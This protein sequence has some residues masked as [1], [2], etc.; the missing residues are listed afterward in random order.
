MLKTSKR[1]RGD[2]AYCNGGFKI[3]H[4]CIRYKKQYAYSTGTHFTFT[5][6][7]KKANDKQCELFVKIV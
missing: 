4:G 1:L 6:T 7:P 5:E 3:C 2:F